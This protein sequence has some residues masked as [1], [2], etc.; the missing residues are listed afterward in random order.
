VKDLIYCTVCSG[1]SFD[2]GEYYLLERYQDDEV[3]EADFDSQSSIPLLGNLYLYICRDCGFVMSFT[4]EKQ[5]LKNK[6][7]NNKT[8]NL[9][10]NI[11]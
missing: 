6:K 10:W 2:E 8:S 1:S 11:R 3:A 5:V 7:K 4:R 9:T